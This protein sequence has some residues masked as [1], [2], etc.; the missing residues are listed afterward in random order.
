MYRKES[1]GCNSKIEIDIS[2]DQEEHCSIDSLLNFMGIIDRRNP[3]L[4]APCST[5]TTSTLFS[6]R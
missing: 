4:S 5:S 6:L 2:A 3:M 1:K